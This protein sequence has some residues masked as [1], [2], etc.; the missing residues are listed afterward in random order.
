M[1]KKVRGG[2]GGGAQANA[3]F[4]VKQKVN[5]FENGQFSGN[6]IFEKKNFLPR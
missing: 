2:K 5:V 3:F 6:L 4:R 1:G